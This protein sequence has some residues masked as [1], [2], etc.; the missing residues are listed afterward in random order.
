MFLA[1][2]L[3]VLRARDLVRGDLLARDAFRVELSTEED[4]LTHTRSGPLF[5]SRSDTVNSYTR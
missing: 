2:P 4:V 5:E 1:M 3:D